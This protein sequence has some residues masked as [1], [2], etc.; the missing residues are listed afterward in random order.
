[1]SLT[2]PLAR[3]IIETYYA[4]KEGRPLPVMPAVPGTPGFTAPPPPTRAVAGGDDEG[5]MR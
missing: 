5:G 4:R 2:Q 3:H 1:M